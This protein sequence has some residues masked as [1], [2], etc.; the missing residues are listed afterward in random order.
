MPKGLDAGT[1]F[2]IAA[3]SDSIKKQRNAF[4]TVD[5]EPNQAKRMLKRQRIPFVEKAKKVHIVGQHAFNY[6]QI[7]QAAQLRRPMRAGLLNPDERDALPILNAIIGELLGKAK[8]NETCVYCVPARPIDQD[9]RVDY[10]EDVLKAIIEG[11][12][13]S[14]KVIEEA[15]A[16]AYEGLVDDNLTGIAISMG[17]GMINCSVLYQGMTAISFSVARGGDWIDNNVSVDTGVSVA[18]VQ[19]IKESSN[20]LDL[21]TGRVYDVYDEG[22]DEANILHAIRSYYGALIQYIL[23]N[24][25]A[26]FEGTANVPQFPEAVPIVIGGGTC[27][28]KG[29]I[30]VFNEQFDQ[31]TFPIQVSEI[32]LIE[33]AH[34]AVARGCL[35]EAQ[36]IE[37]E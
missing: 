17:A 29:F 12:G 30:D 2:Y 24:I 27:L 18:K 31:E 11:Y 6:A 28:V 26:Q 14:A 13:Y 21:T 7:F 19:N 32:R 10:H 15:V 4:L 33:D 35:S 37:S 5:G 9:R 25:K 36:I 1:S 22:S 16:L 23:A 8:D 20:L 3:T 34:T